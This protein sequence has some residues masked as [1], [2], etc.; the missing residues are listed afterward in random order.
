MNRKYLTVADVA[1]A[2]EVSDESVRRWA[3]TGAIAYFRLPSGQLRFRPEVIE[4]ITG[5][6][7]TAGDAAEAAG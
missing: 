2:L 4:E 7:A 6:S 5:E 1:A 3:A